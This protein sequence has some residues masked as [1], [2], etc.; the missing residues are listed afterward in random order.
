MNEVSGDDIS[1]SSPDLNLR[2][3]LIGGISLYLDGVPVLTGKRKALALIGY[4]CAERRSSVTREFAAEFLWSD[5]PEA[6][7]RGS[8]RQVLSDIKKALA[9]TKVWEADR[10]SIKL[11]LNS[12]SV[13]L[14]ELLELLESGKL[15]N[16]LEAGGN[17]ISQLIRG[18]EDMGE[19][20]E[21]W[22]RDFRDY[23]EKCVMTCL[24][25]I[26]QNPNIGNA[27]RRQSAEA[28]LVFDPLNE[29]AARWAMQIFAHA[30]DVAAAIKVYGRL[31]EKLD[32]ELGMDPSEQTQQLMVKIKL[33]ELKPEQPN[34]STA[35]SPHI[36]S[37]SQGLLVGGI[38]KP[39]IAI[40]P[41]Q[42]LGP[43][44]VPEHFTFGT[45]DEIAS[46]LAT[47]N[48][49]SVISSNSTRRLSE[50][51]E[52]FRAELA[53]LQTD[54]F[55]K[56]TVRRSEEQLVISVQLVDFHTAT[57]EWAKVYHATNADLFDVQGDIANNIAIKLI[58]S[59][60]SAELRR[61]SH[62]APDDL[63]AYHL[64]L[65]A[66][67]MAFGLT[68]HEFD[69]AGH[70][71]RSAVAKDPQ[72]S[73]IF[74]SLADW[75]SI[76]LGQRWS[77]HVEN[78]R[79]SLEDAARR[80]IYLDPENGRALAMLGHN[81]TIYKKQYSLARELLDKAIALY[82]NDAETLM[83]GGPTLAFAGESKHAI[84][85]AEIARSLSPN[86][87]YLFRY[88]HFLGIAYYSDGDFSSA[89][90]H[91]L[92]SHAQNPNYVSN[93]RLAAASFIA[94]GKRD[95][96]KHFAQLAMD[97]DP[98][99]RVSEFQRSNPFRNEAAGKEFAAQLLKTGFPL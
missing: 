54:Y 51:N 68:R 67:D 8:L 60:H 6:Q 11:D 44:Q 40:C 5:F 76:R 72:F 92:A 41:I 22:V 90:R 82:P 99:F 59:L 61:T 56:G 49:I 74:F 7:A 83:W 95:D 86:D 31:Y 32:S 30:G 28:A 69:Q 15:P 97:V 16:R 20:F 81:L 88:D 87:P 33:G 58:P 77:S 48:D 64:M 62:C 25:E 79:K 91:A 96:A 43:L 52:R 94:D 35:G 12:V 46:H 65:R 39:R 4:I 24:S 42:C 45:L 13:D 93:L 18:Y 34:D 98:Q 27:E 38:R 63:P 2:L 85:Q 47:M 73:Q 70:L 37:R 17:L 71:L 36:Q 19:A 50:T 23:I 3:E 66:K 80:A 26:Y 55:M 10:T 84:A 53:D 57:V 9:T 14:F 21:Q 29:D 89:A 78:D 75:Y 1:P